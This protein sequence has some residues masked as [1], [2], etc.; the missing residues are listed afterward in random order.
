[1][2]NSV[3]KLI[4]IIE[5]MIFDKDSEKDGLKKTIEKLDKN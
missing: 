3:V 4:E 1:M 5:T 2:L